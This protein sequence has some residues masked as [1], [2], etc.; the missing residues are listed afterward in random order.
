MIKN[1]PKPQT[2]Q[3][4]ANVSECMSGAGK[5]SVRHH[6]F[7]RHSEARFLS[8]DSM[9]LLAPGSG[10]VHR[11]SDLFQ[12]HCKHL[13]PSWSATSRYHLSQAV[14]WHPKYPKYTL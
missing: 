12:M 14:T 3:H 11:G 1:T 4:D 6:E 8:L 10:T 9:K 5:L 2:M 13:R 7:Q